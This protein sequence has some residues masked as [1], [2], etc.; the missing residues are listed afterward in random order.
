[1]AISPVPVRADAEQHRAALLTAACSLVAERGA[2]AIAAREIALRAG[3][4]QA[5]LYRHFPSKQAL[6][7]AVSVDRS[8]C[9]LAW[10]DESAAGRPA[11]VGIVSILERFSAMVSDDREF[12]AKEGLTV[13]HGPVP[14]LP[15]RDEFDAKFARLWRRGQAE[16]HVRADTHHE[17]AMEL[18]GTLR[19]P[20]RRTRGLGLIVNGFSSRAVDTDG[21]FRYVRRSTPAWDR[22]PGFWP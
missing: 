8:R 10:A 5:T 20:Q 13:G 18:A 1:M 15:L 22:T 16:G 12:I 21:L 11:I 17:D 3:L 19:H 4:S 2:K 14:I 9:A 7:D 6:I